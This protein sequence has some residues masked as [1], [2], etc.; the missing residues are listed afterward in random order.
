MRSAVHVN[1]TLNDPSDR[2]K[3]WTVEFAIPY[4]SIAYDRDAATCAYDD[5]TTAIHAEITQIGA[6]L[7]HGMTPA[8]HLQRRRPVNEG[9]AAPALISGEHKA[10]LGFSEET[11]SSKGFSQKTCLY[12]GAI[13]LAKD[14]NKEKKSLWWQ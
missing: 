13:I 1:G 3:G 10:C 4:Q 14:R 7:N 5:S 8:G 6:A 12:G 2:D 11:A 9:R